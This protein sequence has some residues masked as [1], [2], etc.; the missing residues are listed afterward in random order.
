MGK[1]SH[2]AIQNEYRIAFAEGHAF[3]PENVTVQLVDQKFRRQAR[4]QSH[5]SLLLKLNRLPKDW[6]LHTF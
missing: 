2:Y 5:Q 3:A 4:Q 6:L 1:R